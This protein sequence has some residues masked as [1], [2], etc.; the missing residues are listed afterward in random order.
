MSARP[1]QSLVH[2]QMTRRGGGQRGGGPSF[3]A[4]AMFGVVVVVAVATS[5]PTTLASATESTPSA[6][7]RSPMIATS[8]LTLN[9]AANGKTSGGTQTSLDWAGYAVTGT[10]FTNVSGA[11]TQ[12]SATC[13]GK[14]VEQAAFWVGT[15]GYSESD[16]TVQQ[17]GT[18][19]DC[20]KG[21]GN[22]KGGPS[23]YAWYQMYPASDV[24][25]SPSFYPVAPGDAISASVALSGS[26]YVLHVADGTRWTFT[27]TQAPST[28]PL[29]S[30]AEWIAEAPSSC[31]KSTCK[32]LPLPNFGSLGFSKASAN[33]EAISA[34]AFTHYQIN[35]T[36][37]NPKKLKAQTS[38]LTGS[39]SGFT[40]S[41]LHS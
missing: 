21:K 37:K 15:D 2:R 12:P 17:V 29:N 31:S 39:G 34:P 5:L 25:L 1:R 7:F 9:P 22:V 18:D 13:T 30:S 35:M 8:P 10:T 11:W 20:T 28:R 40:V 38:A 3:R 4:L 36:L 19:S 6:S 14:K 41:W 24:V 32:V 27:T 26:D 23:Y 16:P 33:G